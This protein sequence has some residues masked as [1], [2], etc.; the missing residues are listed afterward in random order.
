MF[1]GKKWYS[2][3]C[4]Y[5]RLCD[6][7]QMVTRFVRMRYAA[8]RCDHCAPDELVDEWKAR[9]FQLQPWSGSS[10][11]I[12]RPDLS[13]PPCRGR[14]I[15]H[16]CG[17][18]ERKELAMIEKRRSASFYY[19]YSCSWNLRHSLLR[20]LLVTSF[21]IRLELNSKKRWCCYTTQ[22]VICLILKG[23]NDSLCFSVSTVKKLRRS[24]GDQRW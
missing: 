21:L 22:L 5:V 16:R 9:R 19:I 17:I 7:I 15:I 13:C 6:R 23:E 24:V 11:F 12:C 2:S 10:A 8:T 4:L 20:A 14:A 1:N 18:Y 3:S